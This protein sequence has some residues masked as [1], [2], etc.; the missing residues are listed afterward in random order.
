MNLLNQSHPTLN[1][2]VI[3]VSIES[4]NLWNELSLL[5]GHFA[6]F[7]VTPL[8][9]ISPLY[10]KISSE[11]FKISLDGHGGDECLM[12][13][14]DMIGAAIKIAAPEEQVSSKLLKCI[15]QHTPRHHIFFAKVK[16]A[17]GKIKRMAR[18][19]PAVL[20]NRKNMCHL[21]QRRF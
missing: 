13:Y 11:D 7:S 8:S 6:D 1:R 20:T 3:F 19:K 16:I 12:G 21:K 15:K 9:C 18:L 17:F 2:H 5:T 10:R 4:E 14:P